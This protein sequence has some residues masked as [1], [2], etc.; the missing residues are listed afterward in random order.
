MLN[1]AKSPLIAKSFDC[2]TGSISV[3][4]KKTEN[5]GNI[6]FDDL[7]LD[8]DFGDELNMSGES[9]DKNSRKATLVTKGI[10]TG[11][12]KAVFSPTT[13]KKLV[14]ASL[15]KEAGEILDNANLVTS[16]VSDLY[17]E[18]TK[19]LKPAARELTKQIN[20]LVPDEMRRT[21]AVMEKF[22]RALGVDEAP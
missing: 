10:V 13:A 5:T 6:D 14:R 1:A 12:K 2:F 3:A 8:F 4:K 18:T 9:N 11:A 21:K 7:D 19:E 16:A 22:Q 15:P 20:K 17:D